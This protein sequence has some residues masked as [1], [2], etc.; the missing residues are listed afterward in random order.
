MQIASQDMR[1]LSHDLSESQAAAL[2]RL[3]TRT[4]QR[5]RRDGAGPQYTRLGPRRIRYARSDLEAWLRT[6]LST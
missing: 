6:G 5:Y 4:L 3:S 1:P 2:L